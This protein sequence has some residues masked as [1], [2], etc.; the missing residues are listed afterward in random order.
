[1][2]SRNHS[3]GLPLPTAR[4]PMSRRAGSSSSEASHGSSTSHRSHGSEEQF[5]LSPSQTPASENAPLR[6]MISRY[7]TDH[8]VARNGLLLAKEVNAR[9][10]DSESISKTASYSRVTPSS[11]SRPIAIESSGG[12][13]TDPTS[14][15]SPI[16]PEPLSA[17]G[18]IVGGYFPLHE[19]PLSRVHTPHPFHPDTD[20]ARQSSLQRTAES[21][22]S[23]AETRPLSP[24]HA[25][26]PVH[27]SLSNPRSV[28]TSPDTPI[29]SYIPSGFHD[30]VA[31]PMGKY[32]PSNWEQRH[33]KVPQNRPS[34]ATLPTGPA[35]K[36]ESQ[37][38]KYRG[39]QMPP[40][41]GSDVKRR[42]QQYQRDMVAQAAMAANALIAA[43]GS[44]NSAALSSLRGV[45][46]PRAQLA[47]NFLRTHKPLA[48]RLQPVGSPGP[49]TPM[50]LEAECYLSLGAPGGGM[51]A[52]FSGLE[53]GP[54]AGKGKQ[55][56]KDSC[57]SPLELSAAS[58]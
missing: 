4:R 21:S 25:S 1:M 57:S 35:I 42:L 54:R 41:P 7:A 36:S 18:D 30:N 37:V 50:S 38:P 12:R 40:R 58:I 48:P 53:I 55:R 32:Y 22:K 47:A 27:G 11:K 26:E 49:V 51:A 5:V 52:D 24:A 2:E 34:T 20:M 29:S 15:S 3:L 16:P 56:R 43:G 45:P 8:A 33:G 46:L 13:P 28:L 23:G 17:R 6:V 31:L 44:A 19:D 39:E 10:R 14:T 9:S